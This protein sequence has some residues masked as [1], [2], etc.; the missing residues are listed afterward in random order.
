MDL[1]RLVFGHLLGKGK[2]G[3]GDRGEVKGTG[4]SFVHYSFAEV[5][6]TGCSFVHYSFAAEAHEEA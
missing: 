2:E 4:C 3:K 6:G 5:K 1:N